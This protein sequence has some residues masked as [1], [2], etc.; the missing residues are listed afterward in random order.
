MCKSNAIKIVFILLIF[1]LIIIWKNIFFFKVK[2]ES[3]WIYKYVGEGIDQ[4][5]ISYGESNDD[6]DYTIL[7]LEEK[8]KSHY[9]YC[10]IRNK[11]WV[12]FTF[13]NNFLSIKNVE[14]N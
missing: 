10:E 7:E 12:D 14:C 8:Y 5:S 3:H 11:N 6:Y 2:P 4:M 9:T 13:L 1:I